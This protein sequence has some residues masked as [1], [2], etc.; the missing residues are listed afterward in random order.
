MPVYKTRIL[1]SH[2]SASGFHISFLY[3]R[4]LI[5]AMR[6]RRRLMQ[7]SCVNR[8]VQ[9]ISPLWRELYW[10]FIRGLVLQ[11][12][13]GGSGR[14]YWIKLRR[15]CGG[16]SFEFL[17]LAVWMFV[18][19]RIHF[20]IYYRKTWAIMKCGTLALGQSLHH[21]Y[22]ASLISLLEKSTCPST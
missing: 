9:Y 15:E 4:R 13:S 17:L 11:G 1:Y 14:G 22:I 18:S 19:L 20:P 5:E 21:L 6:L 2:E 7:I 10:I 12:R 3:Q 8:A 16:Y